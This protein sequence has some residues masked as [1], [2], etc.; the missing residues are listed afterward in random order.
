MRSTL[1]I[2]LILGI[3]FLGCSAPEQSA[4]TP[5]NTPTQT[6]TPPKIVPQTTPPVQTT[7]VS[8]SAEDLGITDIERDLKEMEDILSELESLENMSFEI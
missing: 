7:P 2:F 3:L 4:E 6:T 8:V 1:P 5:S